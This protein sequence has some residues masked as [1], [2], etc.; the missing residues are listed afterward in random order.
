M[1]RMAQ[2]LICTLLIVGMYLSASM[3]GH[4]SQQKA[5]DIQIDSISII[6]NTGFTTEEYRCNS[7]INSDRLA[8]VMSIL[9]DMMEQQELDETFCDGKLQINISYKDGNRK[10]L[11][12][13]AGSTSEQRLEKEI[14]GRYIPL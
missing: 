13:K 2:L 3:T 8:N 6:Y 5:N 10:V 14:A 1:K 7:K 9:S 12:S 11:Y 4:V